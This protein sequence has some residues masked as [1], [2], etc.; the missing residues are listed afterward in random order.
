MLWLMYWL[1]YLDRN[2]ITL[3]Q[4]NGISKQLKLAVA[5]GHANDSF[6]YLI[7]LC[8]SVARETT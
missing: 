2:A 5:C 8:G 6:D 1:S 3:A 4:I 7:K